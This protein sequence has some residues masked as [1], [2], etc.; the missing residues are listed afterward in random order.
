MAVRSSHENPEIVALYEHYYGKPLSPKAKQLLHTDYQDRS[1]DLGE[2]G[3]V[4]KMSQRKIKTVQILVDVLMFLALLILLVTPI[5]IRIIRGA[6]GGRP[7]WGLYRSFHE[8]SG[9]VIAGLMILH[10]ILNFRQIFAVKGF[11]KYPKIT[12]IQ[13]TVMFIMLISMAISITS[14]AMWGIQGQ[15]ASVP[16]RAVH[17]VTSWLAFV[18]MG[19][20]MGMSS[21]KLM[22]FFYSPKST[23]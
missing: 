4:N 7:E 22:S 8:W 11:F 9:W 14:G 13:Y 5:I 10:I 23:K 16:L 15:A 19:F 6:G 17:S 18:A 12:K 21:H 1:Q 2:K 20:H 3:A